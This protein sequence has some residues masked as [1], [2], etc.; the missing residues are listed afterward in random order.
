MKDGGKQ[1]KIYAVL[2]YTTILIICFMMS[3]YLNFYIYTEVSV[4][5]NIK[6][7]NVFDE[8][9]LPISFPM[10]SYLFLPWCLYLCLY[11]KCLYQTNLFS[12]LVDALKLVKSNVKHSTS[13]LDKWNVTKLLLLHTL[14]SILLCALVECV[15]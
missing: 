8:S 12:T 14:L 5:K 4:Q 13:A 9:A 6:S 3:K 10:I 15:L 1:C 7:G 11:Y 2:R